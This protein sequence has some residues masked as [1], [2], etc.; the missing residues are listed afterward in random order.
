MR[1]ILACAKFRMAAGPLIVLWAPLMALLSHGARADGD[2]ISPSDERVRLSL[3]VMHVSS[4]TTVRVDSSTGVP[5]TVVNAEDQFGLAESNVEPMFEAVVRVATRH[6]LMFDYFTLDRSGNA[7]VGEDPINFRDVVL[8]PNDPLQTRLSLRTF[9]IT[10]GYSFWHSEKLEIAATLG[11]HA[12]E[13]SASVKV[14]TQTTHIIQNEDQAGPAPTVGLAATWVVSRRFY[15]DG[16]AQYL[17]VHVSDLE[18]SLGVYE[19]NALYRFRPN[20]S[21]GLGYTD[22]STHLNSTKSTGGGL[23]DFDSK[24]PQLFVRVAF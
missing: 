1:K 5:G 20:V 15:L 17:N 24:G 9:G 21:F 12:A 7:I 11:V 2:Y 4:A 10:Y 18:G 8:Q 23:F 13:I 22:I 19:F 3:G 14:Q 16:R 6:R